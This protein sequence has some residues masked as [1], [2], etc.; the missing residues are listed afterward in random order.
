MEPLAC[1]QRRAGRFEAS[2]VLDADTCVAIAS[3][4]SGGIEV[5]D[6]LAFGMPYS[7]LDDSYARYHWDANWDYVEFLDGFTKPLYVL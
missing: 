3:A 6:S 4:M 5:D 2:R 1:Q 7:R